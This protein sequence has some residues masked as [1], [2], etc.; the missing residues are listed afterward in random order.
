MPIVF[1]KGRSALDAYV[2]AAF[3]EVLDL[4]LHH[5]FAADFPL[6][7]LLGKLLPP[8]EEIDA[9]G[10]AFQVDDRLFP[11]LQD[12]GIQFRHGVK[13]LQPR[14]NTYAALLHGITSPPF[15]S[16]AAPCCPAYVSAALF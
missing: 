3:R 4:L 9:I 2:A 16:D 11:L 14:S 13:Y 10:R 12:R 5:L 6:S 15:A 1:E 8:A 7:D